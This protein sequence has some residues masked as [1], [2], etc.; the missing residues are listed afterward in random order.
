MPTPRVDLHD[1]DLD[2]E[3]TV[4]DAADTL[5]R[6]ELVLLPTETVY[7]IAA[8]IDQPAALERLETLRTKP[9]PLTPHLPDAAAV[10]NYLPEVPLHARRLLQKLWPGPVAL[11]FSVNEA[12]QREVAGRLGV[13]P[14][15]LFSSD[16]QITLRCPDEP[17]TQAVL[18]DADQ[19]VVLTRNGLPGG[20][21][22]DRPPAD[23]EL[24]AG[25]SLVLDA[26]PTRYS[27]SSTVIAVD[28]KGWSVRREGIYDKRIIDRLLRTTILFVCSGN[29]CRSPMAMALARTEIAKQ[30]GVEAKDLEERGIEVIS[31]GSVA[32]PGMRA[33][34]EAVEAVA[35]LGADL[36]SHR[37]QPL[38]VGLLNRADLIVAMTRSHLS[39]VLDL[40]PSAASK[41]VLLDPQG[42]ID[43]PI[44]MSAP[45]YQKLAQRMT[46]LIRSR[47]ADSGLKLA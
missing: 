28:D 3:Q 30:L 43:D 4:R 21:A 33:A 38:S 45:V 34:A 2:L 47:L 17:F 10:E 42:D 36:S 24:P 15:L 13:D 12:A 22:A 14:S 18:R 44:G 8:R 9:G 29:T 19:P 46:S 35:G 37:S 32:M 25:V 23:D 27:K 26:G 11:A 7:G 39:A 6:G 5:R 31:A 41:T 20:S 16:G 40:L 1:L